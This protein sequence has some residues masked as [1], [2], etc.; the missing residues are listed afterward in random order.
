MTASAQILG[1][2][3][4]YRIGSSVVLG[5]NIGSDVV[6]QTLI[7]GLVVLLTGTLHFRRYFLWKSMLPMIGTTI[8]CIILGWDRTYSRLDGAILF[9]T[10]IAYTYFLYWDERKYYKREPQHA[11]IEHKALSGRIALRDSV[12]ALVAMACTVFGAQIVLQVTQLVVEHTGIG[13]SFIGVVTL[14][15]ASALPELVTALSGVRANAHGVSLGTL[16]VSNITDPLVAIGGGA[17]LSTYW[18]PGPLLYW[19]LP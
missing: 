7:M 13:G 3:L 11:N 14:G 5:A 12:V 8:M 16:V 15:V 10:F 4:D 18:A 9:G 1:G 19:D 17:L 6:Q 2:R